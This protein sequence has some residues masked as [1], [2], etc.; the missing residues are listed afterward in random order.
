MNRG[1]LRVGVAL[2]LVLTGCDGI[3][4]IQELSYHGVDAGHGIHDA[5]HDAHDAF[6]EAAHDKADAPHDTDRDASH[7]AGHD[8]A[9]DGGSGGAD[10]TSD[11]SDA[12]VT[13][14]NC[15][16]VLAMNPTATTGPYTIQPAGQSPLLAYCDMVTSG[17]GWTEVF[18]QDITVAPGY[19]PTA[20]WVEGVNMGSP[21]SG[22]Y[23]IL[24]LLSELK[25]AADYELR[26]EWPTA[27]SAGSVQWTQVENPL[28]APDTPT[29]SGVTMAPA[30]QEGCG[31][32]R[33]LAP[34]QS[35]PSTL[36]GDS[37]ENC[38][39][40]AIGTPQ[41]WGESGD[42]SP[43]GIPSY[44]NNGDHPTP[45]ARLWVR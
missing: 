15:A 35:E 20:T 24:S 26:I 22:Q 34:T 1:G 19:R 13:P 10:A 3:L 41:P 33:G 17:G 7:D 28:T 30:A 11:H 16:A 21:N 40:W 36:D 9:R 32:F 23:S 31:D 44:T 43:G 45:H 29:I 39:Y 42:A 12:N 25:T 37:Q 27:P 2:A 6:R 18:D 5:G 38:F 8:A 14:A 4:A